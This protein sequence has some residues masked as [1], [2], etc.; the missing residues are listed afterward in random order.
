[1][2]KSIV[3]ATALALAFLPL[4]DGAFAQKCRPGKYCPP[5]SA[6]S[7]IPTP[8]VCFYTATEYKGL[9]FCETGTRSVATIP[10]QWRNKIKS[11]TVGD[12]TTVRLCPDDVLQGD[13]AVIGQDTAKLEPGLFNQVQSYD[14]R[15]AY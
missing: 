13:C 4:A 6:S 2:K 3:T 12:H 11:I 5:A 10:A 15:T 8:E 7:S 9:F 1:M 14:I